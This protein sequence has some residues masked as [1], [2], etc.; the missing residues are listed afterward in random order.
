MTTVGVTGHQNIP[1]DAYA[2]IEAQIKNLLSGEPSLVGVSSLAVGADQLFA[3]IVLRLG[4]RLCVV[5]PSKRYEE[6]FSGHG[7]GSFNRLLQKA[8]E[9]TVLPNPSPTEAAFFAA[10]RTIV[11][12]SDVLCAVWDGAEARGLGGA[13]D[14]VSYARETLKQVVVIWPSGVVR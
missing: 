5:L 9:V 10:G 3:K 4:G 2:F 14:V 7:L 11:D 8:D 1:S 13:G 6:T 12:Q